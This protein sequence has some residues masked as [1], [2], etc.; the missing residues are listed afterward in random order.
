[1]ATDAAFDYDDLMGS[2][3][4]AW[5]SRLTW[6][7]L[8]G[9]LIAAVAT[10]VW[11]QFLR[12]GGTATVAVQTATVS[13][14]NVTKTVS[15]SGTVAAQSTTNLNFTNTG[16]ASARITKV[17]V[18]LGQQVKQGD[19]LAE[20]D[21]TDAQTALNSAKLSLATQ[22]S[23]LDQLLQGGT[24]S[25]LASADQSVQQAQANYDKAVRAM[26]DLQ[27]PADATTIETAQQA[28]TTAQA[29]LQQAKDARAKIDTD[30]SASVATA[31][32]GVTK[33]QNALTAAQQTQSNAAANIST[34]QAILNSAETAYVRLSPLPTPAVS[35]CPGPRP[36]RSRRQIRQHCSA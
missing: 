8:L 1:M 9:V 21:A 30:K 29:Q 28:V 23:K 26:H 34:A 31:Q 33:A 27:A 2:A 24:A 14:G 19:V 18:K 7:A 17:D 16:T 5:R 32:S 11:W 10:G 12:G 35:F 6:L 13:V 22:Q 15:T 20:I 4:N 3:G 36:R 25:A